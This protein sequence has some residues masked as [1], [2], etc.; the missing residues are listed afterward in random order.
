MK[1]ARNTENLKQPNRRR[2]SRKGVALVMVLTVTALATIMIL[3]FFSLATSENRASATYSRGLQAQQVGEQAVNLVIAQLRKATSDPNVS[4]ASQPGA[5]RTWSR[6]GDFHRGYKLYSDDQLEEIDENKL[7]EEDF[8]EAKNWSSRPAEFVDLNEPV[9]RGE[10]VYFPIVDPLARDEP[11]WPKSI[12]GDSDDAGVEGFDFNFTSALTVPPGQMQQRVQ[13]VNGLGHLALPVRWIY[14][15]ADGT[16]GVVR[17]DRFQAFNGGKVPTADNQIVARFAYWADDETAK[18]NLNTHAGGLAWD[19]PRV[20]GE[21]DMDMGRYQPAQREWQ[22]YPGHPATTHLSPALAPGVVDIVRDRRAMELIY[23]VVPRVVGGGSEAGTRKTSIVDEKERNG[24]I[25]DKNPLFPSVDEYIMA[26]NRE[27][28]RFPQADGQTAS[29]EEMQD[30]L[31]RLRFFLTVTSRAPET[32]LFNTPKISVWP[33]HNINDEDYRTPFDQ[34]IAF[35]STIGNGHE[36]YFRRENEDSAT[37]D[38]D[39]IQR[40]RELYQFLDRYTK[41]PIPGVGEAFSDKYNDEDRLQLLTSI[42]DYIRSTN[43]HDDTLYQ[44]DWEDV[45]QSDNTNDHRT[46]TNPRAKNQ[47]REELGQTGVHKGHGQ[48]TPIR[49]S[50]GGVDTQGYGRFYTLKDAAIVVI[51]CG[52]GDNTFG[53]GRVEPQFPGWTVYGQA[54]RE[55]EIGGFAYSNIPPLHLDPDTLRNEGARNSWMDNNGPMEYPLWIKEWL[56][57]NGYVDWNARRLA[58]DTE[59]EPWN[60]VKEIIRPAFDPNNWNFNLL[61]RLPNY[62]ELDGDGNVAL[63]HQEWWEANRGLLKDFSNADRLGDGEKLLQ[64]ALVFHLFTPSMGWVPIS[65]DISVQI[66]MDS[67]INFNN[68]PRGRFLSN[69]DP[70]GNALAG[71]SDRQWWY[72]NRR[73][74][75]WHDRHAGGVKPMSY[76]LSSEDQPGRFTPIDP[77]YAGAE[78]Y[79]RYHWITAPFTVAGDFLQFNGGNVAFSIYAH[80]D[81]NQRSAPR[82]GVGPELVQRV[83][84]D[85]D[86]FS[87]PVP[88]LAR[89][90]HGHINDVEHF[91]HPRPAPELWSLGRQGANPFY[92]LSTESEITGRIHG[93]NAWN[94]RLIER[95]GEMGINMDVVRSVG[96]QHGDLRMTAVQRSLSSGASGASGLAWYGP[97][98]NYANSNERM[99]HDLSLTPGWRYAGADGE[100]EP[101]MQILPGLQY[102]GKSPANMIGEK[103]TY[104]SA[105]VQRYGDWDNAMGTLVD[106]PYINKPDEG[107]T[108]SLFLRTITTEPNAWDL[109]RDYGDVPYFVRDYLHEAG[110]PAYFSPNRI[111]NGPGMF[112]SLPTQAKSN[113][114]WQTLL[115]RPEAGSDHPG[116]EDPKDHYLMD[117]FWMP[118]V[119]PYAISEP[120][121]TAG[122]VNLNYQMLPFRHVKRSTAMRG[123]LRSEFMVLVPTP[124]SSPSMYTTSYK[125][126]QGRGRGWHWRDKPF[127]GFLQGKRL[128]A[129]ILEEKTLEQFQEKFDE[130]EI[131]KSASEICEIH[132]IPQQVAERMGASSSKNQLESYTPTVAQMESGKFWDDH[133]AVG[134]N[135]RERPYGNIYQ[136]TTTRSNTFKVHFRAQVINQG[137]RTDPAAYAQFD[138]ELDSVVAEYRGSSIVERYID[139]NDRRIPDYATATNPPSIGEF[140][141]FRVINPTRFAP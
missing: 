52:T 7:V 23:G 126:Q 90:R 4:W 42:F 80:G 135:A 9:I 94:G 92:N 30:I 60:E 108:H 134:D 5:V 119:E 15:L 96:A 28:N 29:A 64:A 95:D 55:G 50:Y 87:C 139:P 82:S 2:G 141:R 105:Q 61:Y 129:I 123:V 67:A 37:H 39:D 19:T 66:E 102:R 24:L 70:L 72:A 31:E 17:G 12:G 98:F 35:C 115:F 58:R 114:P 101:D 116:A 63:S 71:S 132:L 16:L 62:P 47:K 44:E 79:N 32:T 11:K 38:Y 40:N 8:A 53:G 78:P 125:H 85:F 75:S 118:V 59:P 73:Q 124:S 110:S 48:V 10:K 74:T 33:V 113:Q 88:L 109:R 36:Y 14:Q 46:Y 117:L 26:P 103:S 57:A 81:S 20:G 104:A 49:I 120:F 111:S 34:L 18:L 56:T 130:G 112:G 136:R 100:S 83:E 45:F 91:H 27:P 93:I 86:S 99:A 6:L 3:T 13:Q 131:F 97:H 138:D 137:R 140:Y 25:A 69:Y 22:R 133:L 43:L 121:S 41:K 65:P 89:G 76:F 106:G 77:G 127:G 128:R 21:A 84:L 51:C 1:T 122:R 54:G 107:N 68:A